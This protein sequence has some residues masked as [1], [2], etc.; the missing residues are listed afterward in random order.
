MAHEVP[1]FGDAYDPREQLLPTEEEMPFVDLNVGEESYHM[2][3]RDTLVRT[4][5]VGNGEY[6]HVLHEYGAGKSIFIF[7]SHMLNDQG[8]ELM[9]LFEV[10][11]FPHRHDPILDDE[12]IDLFSRME[13]QAIDSTIDALIQGGRPETQ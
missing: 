13:S 2:T 7:F 12:T 5:S 3:W 10:H 11:S 4:F 1:Q 8:S 9:S 6:D